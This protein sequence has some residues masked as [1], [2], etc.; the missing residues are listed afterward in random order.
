VR[1]R[2]GG[3][4]VADSLPP[5]QPPPL[6]VLG[7]WRDTCDHWV[8]VEVGVAALAAE[9][10][11]GRAIDALEALTARLDELLDDVASFRRVDVRL[12]MGLAEATGSARLVTAM[13]EVRGEMT[14]LIALIAYPREVLRSSN[15][16]HRRLL[17]AIRRHDEAAAAAEMLE[18]V[19]DTEHVL[20]GLLPST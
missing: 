8:A 10:A 3:T 13:T 18:H 17:A 14:G 12:H 7:A 15:R 2:S 20:A 5:T 6:E 9:R 19:H 1:G 4:F 16:Q 11:A